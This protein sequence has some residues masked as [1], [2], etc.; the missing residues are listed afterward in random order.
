MAYAARNA[1]VAPIAPAIP[2]WRIGV[3]GTSSR[4]MNPRNMQVLLQN[5]GVTVCFTASHT[6]PLPSACRSPRIR[7]QLKVRK[8]IGES[9]ITNTMVERL[10]VSGPMGICSIWFASN[11]QALE[12]AQAMKVP[13]RIQSER[14]IRSST[15]PKIHTAA[16]LKTRRSRARFRAINSLTYGTPEITTLNPGRSNRCCTASIL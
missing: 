16:R 12:S 13:S 6:G 8:T 10:A 5:E 15:T 3:D 1:I 2:R 4:L 14:K 7:F 11:V 9:V